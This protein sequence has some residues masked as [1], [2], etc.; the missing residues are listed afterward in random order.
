MLLGFIVDL[1]GLGAFVC[2]FGQLVDWLF[3]V[4][5]SICTVFWALPVLRT[6]GNI[7]RY[8]TA[9]TGSVETGQLHRGPDA[10]GGLLQRHSPECPT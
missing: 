1:I 7:D 5:F 6:F 10:K 3:L 2:L 9:P 4:C 8:T